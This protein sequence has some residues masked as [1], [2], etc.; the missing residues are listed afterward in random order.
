MNSI[1]VSSLLSTMFKYSEELSI[2][3]DL[4]PDFN[5]IDAVKTLTEL[6]ECQEYV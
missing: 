5:Y 6:D 1:V 3:A 2:L 4:D